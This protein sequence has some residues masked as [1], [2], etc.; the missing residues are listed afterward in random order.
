MES[1]FIWYLAVEQFSKWICKF[2]Y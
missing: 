2:S 1:N